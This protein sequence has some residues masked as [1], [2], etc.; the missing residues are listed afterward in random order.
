[1]FQYYRFLSMF[2][3]LAPRAQPSTPCSFLNIIRNH[4]S[5]ATTMLSFKTKLF[6][7]FRPYTKRLRTQMA[8]AANRWRPGA[9]KAGLC[10]TRVCER[11][12]KC[13]S[14]FE[15]WGPSA[16]KFARSSRPIPTRETRFP[17]F[18]PTGLHAACW[19]SN[20]IHSRMCRGWKYRKN[21]DPQTNQH[22]AVG[23]A[24]FAL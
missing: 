2:S 18:G 23:D 15:W 5:R 11:A 21:R 17:L 16:T 6:S 14:K 22:C 19:N 12:P 7:L 9:A 20:W 24:Y 13:G 10:A 4:S 8:A 1:M 3:P